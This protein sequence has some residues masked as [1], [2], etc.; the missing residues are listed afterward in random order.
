M[1]DKKLKRIIDF[2]LAS[3]ISLVI[4]IITLTII[5]IILSFSGEDDAF[6]RFVNITD[7]SLLTN[8]IIF[9]F[10]EITFMVVFIWR[11]VIKKASN[12]DIYKDLI[13]GSGVRESHA[14]FMGT[15]GKRDILLYAVY[16]L[17][18]AAAMTAAY[19]AKIDYMGKGIM[20][21]SLGE[22]IV[23]FVYFLCMHQALFYLIPLPFVGFFLNIA[24]F[25]GGYSLCIYVL[26]KRW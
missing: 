1:S 7:I 9:S 5:S 14:K 12:A 21:P 6:T 2:L 13:A 17:P 22:N 26:L 24:I 3:L 25:A 18:M 15:Y 20:L 11:F 10:L 8:I 23:G 16:S 4:G 19:F